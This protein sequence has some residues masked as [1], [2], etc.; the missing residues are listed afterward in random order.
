MILLL[1]GVLGCGPTGDPSAALEPMLLARHPEW[2]EQLSLAP[3]SRNLVPD[4][5]P[6]VGP[7]KPVRT[8]GE[9]T[10]WEAPIPIRPRNLFFSKAPP[11]MKVKKGGRTLTFRDATRS[12]QVDTWDFNERTLLIRRQNGSGPPETGEYQLSYARAVERER[13]LNLEMS[14]MEP[15]AFAF[16]S[17]QLR[18]QTRTGVFLPA[19]SVVTWK[20]N[21]PEGAQLDLQAVVLP[22]EFSA[23][24]RSDGAVLVVEANGEE[25]DRQKLAVGKWSRVR[26]DLSD[27]AGEGVSLTARTEGGGSNALDY[28]FL[29]EPI[30]RVPVKEPKRLLLVFI[31]TLRPDHLGFHGYERDTTPRLDAWAQGA[32]VF[33]NARSVAPWTLPS[34]RTALTGQPPEAWSQAEPLQNRLAKA[35]WATGAFVGNIYLSSNFDMGEGWSHHGVVNW[36]VASVQVRKVKRFF[37]RHAHQDAMAMLHLMDMHL[38]YEEPLRYRKIWAGETPDGLTGGALRHAIL[39]EER[40]HPEEVREWLLA[41]YDQNLRYLDDQLSDLFAE[42]GD[43]VPVVIFSDHGEEFWDHDGFEHGHTLYDELLRVPLVVR[44]PG[45]PAGTSDAP[46]SLLDLT[47]TVLDLVG[48][49][50]EGLKGTSLLGVAGGDSQ[51]AQAL[52]D[53]GLAVGRPLYGEERWGVVHGNQKWTTHEGREAVFDLGADPLEKENL[54]KEADLD[55][56]RAAFAGALG[57]EAPVS[58]RLKPS[59]SSGTP[60]SDLVVRVTHPAGFARAWMGADPIRKSDMDLSFSPSEVVITFKAGARGS[61]EVYLEPVGNPED[62]GGLTLIVDTGKGDKVISAREE[63]AATPDGEKHTLLRGRGGGR[64]FTVSY[65]LAPVPEE[66]AEEINAFD[67]EVAQELEAL[68]YV[69]GG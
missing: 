19:P 68:G 9:V 37:K 22:P 42:L 33:E 16:R 21:V 60:K 51:A 27:A 13:S 48:L 39:K 7:F 58:W 26:V 67:P 45:V 4:A 49:P 46:V 57:R 65:G 2:V 35:G 64:S 1:L 23:G 36:P 41:R 30:L 24:E 15:E 5:A 43:D 17:L 55:A 25:V 11:G 40:K 66:G 50:W 32:H 31:D 59:N 53:R 6:V 12:N 38:P 14:G 63:L 18:E 28:V 52:A 8:L 69:E 54:S 10:T 56:H 3:S 47:P 29:A 34:A 44:A 20:V 62:F 61:R